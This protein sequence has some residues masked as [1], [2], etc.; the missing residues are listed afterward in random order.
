MG[1]QG[2]DRHALRLSHT[3]ALDLL[4]PELQQAPAAAPSSLQQP[5]MQRSDTAAAHVGV[6]ARANGSAEEGTVPAVAQHRLP[7]AAAAAAAGE[8][9]A[10]PCRALGP[11]LHALLEYLV[12]IGRKG[13]DACCAAAAVQSCV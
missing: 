4:L 11:A 3:Q 1:V 13:R 2:T 5:S 10:P 9:R 7:T 8:G 12:S 6:A